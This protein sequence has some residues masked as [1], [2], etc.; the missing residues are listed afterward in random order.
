MIPLKLLSPKLML[1]HWLL[2]ERSQGDYWDS[3]RN[4]IKLF[5]NTKRIQFF[6]N[7]NIIVLKILF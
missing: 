6:I 2:T 1:I 3:L 4:E 7:F 5:S